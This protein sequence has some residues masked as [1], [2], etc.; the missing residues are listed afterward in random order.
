MQNVF[1]HQLTVTRVLDLHQRILPYVKAKAYF[2]ASKVKIHWIS[3]FSTKN[4]DIKLLET[5]N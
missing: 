1:K 2:A 3:I 4:R 5:V